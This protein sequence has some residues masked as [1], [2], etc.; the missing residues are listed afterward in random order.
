MP[1]IRLEFGNREDFDDPRKEWRRL[2]LLMEI[3]LTTL[4]VSVILGTASAAQNFELRSRAI[5]GYQGGGDDGHA[6]PG[7]PR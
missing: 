6:D 3:V 7:Y 4:L 2:T 5:I 1:R